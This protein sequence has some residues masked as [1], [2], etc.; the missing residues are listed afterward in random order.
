MVH[1]IPI[2]FFG[3]PPPIVSTNGNLNSVHWFKLI[4]R[5]LLGSV[6]ENPAK[7]SLLSDSQVSEMFFNAFQKSF[8]YHLCNSREHAKVLTPCR[9]QHE[10]SSS[11]S[12]QRYLFL[13]I[14]KI[15][16]S[17]DLQM[18]GRSYVETAGAVLNSSAGRPS[19]PKA[20]SR[21]RAR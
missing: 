12:W 11:E 18:S 2:S 7:T 8:S 17:Q 10:Y 6:Q 15:S 19:K 20:L 21:F 16:D 14:R 9:T 5:V 1:I 3:N 4:Q 13:L